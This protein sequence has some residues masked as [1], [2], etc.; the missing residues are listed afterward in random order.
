LI[1]F[2]KQFVVALYCFA[3]LSL[4]WVLKPRNSK[5]FW[6]LKTE[7]ELSVP[8]NLSALLRQRVS[9]L[10]H[11]VELALAA[12]AVIGREFHFE[13]LRGMGVL[14]DGEILDA[15]DSAL[16]VRLIEE[17]SMGYRFHHPLI[18]RTL[19]ESLSRVRRA[20]LHTRA[21]EAIEVIFALRPGGLSQQIE[22]LAYHYDLS[23]RRDRALPYLIQAGEN[24]AN[25]YE[26]GRASCR[27]RV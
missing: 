9:R 26:I 27:E 13:I 21:A 20:N 19:Y 15:L 25:V 6:S 1:H 3:S 24:A 17:T 5:I 12:A 18:R 16:A 8:E 11:N 2:I 22:I 10:G 7:E 23:D 14:L 4:N